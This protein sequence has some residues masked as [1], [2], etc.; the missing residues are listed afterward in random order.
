VF[1]LYNPQHDLE[2]GEFWQERRSGEFR[3]DGKDVG[4]AAAYTKDR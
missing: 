1:V 2:M 4:E 3:R